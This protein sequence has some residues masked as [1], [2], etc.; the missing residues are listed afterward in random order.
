MAEVDFAALFDTV[1]GALALISPDLV[2]VTV[3]RAYEELLDRPREEIVGRS[4]FEVF[5]GG[6]SPGEAQALRSSLER[7]LAGGEPDTLMLQR[8]DIEVPGRPGIFEERYWNVINAPLRDAEGEVRGIVNQSQEVTA[9]IR[10]MEQGGSRAFAGTAL[11]HLAALEAQ[12]FSQTSELHEINQRLRRS[13]AQ[14]H[15]TSET[16]RKAVRQ[17][18]EAVADTSHDLRGPLTGL[19][20]RLQDALESPEVD[21]REVLLAS[22]QDAERLGDII[23]D[24]LELARLE[25]GVPIATEPVDLTHLVRGELAYHV[26][27]ITIDTHLAPKVI[28]AGSLIRLTR[29]VGNLLANAERH[30]R[31]IL[32]INVGRQGDQAVLE[33]VDDGPGIPDADKEKVFDRF[34]RGTDARRSDPQG[35]GLGLAISRQIAQDHGGTLH[36]AD[37]ADGTPGARL[38]LRLPLLSP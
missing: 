13:E 6:S 20:L 1:P 35:S 22:L 15:R 10:Q 8:Y 14:E 27:P 3:N 21:P 11:P 31:S 12:L 9:F 33:V 24:L 19:Q 5:P 26:P 4:V 7:A 32:E 30:A 18:R 23:G 17:Q 34:F 29:L 2:F 38:I 28:V 16:L 25:A 36:V 37:R